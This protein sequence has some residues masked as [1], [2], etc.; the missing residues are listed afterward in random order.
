[1]GLHRGEVE[2]SATHDYQAPVLHRLGALLAAGH[3]AQV[4]LSA[5]VREA[6]GERL[7]DGVIALSLGTHRLRDLVAAQE[8]WQLVIPGVTTT[9]LLG[10]RAYERA[11][12]AG[13]ALS[14]D[15]AISEALEIAHQIAER[16]ET[17]A[18]YS[19]GRR[20]AAATSQ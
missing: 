19:P 15:E 10:D 18:R 2:P 1:M 8:I 20:S 9:F 7:P 6:V 12:A 4:L 3:G 11:W 5:A 14:L 16:A 13:R 17:P